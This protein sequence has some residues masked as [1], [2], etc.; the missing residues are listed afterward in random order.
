MTAAAE[1]LWNVGQQVYVR[2]FG[3]GAPWLEGK[4]QKYTGPVSFKVLLEGGRVVRRHL[5]HIMH[6]SLW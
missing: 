6:E 1:R 4:I 5:H 2:N 3:Y